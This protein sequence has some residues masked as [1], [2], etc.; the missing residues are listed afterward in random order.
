MSGFLT[1]LLDPY[2]LLFLLLGAG[3]AILW[4]RRRVPIGRLLLTTLAFA[5][6]AVISTPAIAYLSLGTLEWRYPPVEGMPDGA[7]AIVVL[8][9][10]MNPP[11]TV[12]PRAEM[13]AD[14]LARCLHAVAVY[15]GGRPC[16]VVVCGGRIAPGASTPPLAHLMR[17]FL[18]DL[19]FD[20]EAIIV[21]DRSRT[22]HENAVECSKLLRERGIGEVVLVTDAVHMFRALHSFRKHGIL[23]VPSACHHGATEFEWSVWG[24]LP[25]VGAV[26]GHQRAFHEWLGSAWYWIRG[27]L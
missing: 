27:Y 1:G 19:G 8:G 2:R 15:R 20:D 4:R 16:P 3:I 25:S 24:F 18:S 6:L 10:G 7:E 9:G 26:Q 23:A 13:N 5:A 12:R 22:T 17:D 11:D 14:T 21:E